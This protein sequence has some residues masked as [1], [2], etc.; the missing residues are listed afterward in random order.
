MKR[1]IENA[2]WALVGALLVILGLA[3]VDAIEYHAR[4][5]GTAYVKT[6][7]LTRICVVDGEIV[8]P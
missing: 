8:E 4:C 1:G 6:N 5:E 2:L 3:L 7:G